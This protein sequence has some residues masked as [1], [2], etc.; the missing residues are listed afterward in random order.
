MKYY[1]AKDSLG[2]LFDEDRLRL[3]NDM[4]LYARKNKDYDHKILYQAED[5]LFKHGRL[6]SST[7]NFLLDEYERYSM[8]DSL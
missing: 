6:S 4:L 1:P 3:I 7:Y 2:L 8:W 5:D